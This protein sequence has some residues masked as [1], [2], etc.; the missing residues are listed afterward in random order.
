MRAER[1]RSRGRMPPMPVPAMPGGM[2]GSP[3][4]PGAS[5]VVSPGAGAGNQ[6]AASAAVKAAVAQ[7]HQALM[8]F[9]VNSPNYKAVDQALA[10][11]TPMFGGAEQSNLVPAA[12]LQ[13]AQAAKS[14]QTP[15]GSAA[16]PMAPSPPPGGGASPPGMP[17][18][19]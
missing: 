2:A 5:P 18:A 7:L 3:A 14:G 1:P 8:A 13:Q 9:P 6:A 11:L 4:G 15:V 10:K 16:P 12:I 19:A 17:A